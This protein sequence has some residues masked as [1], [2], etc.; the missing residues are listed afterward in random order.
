MKNTPDDNDFAVSTFRNCIPIFSAL[1]DAKR[2]DIILLLAEHEPLNVNQIAE[3]IELSRP[4][5]SHHLKILR[6]VGLVSVDRKGTE[7]NYS[8]E[9]GDA[10][11]TIKQLVET[12]EKA[13]L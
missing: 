13:C 11:V 6:D 8:L 4:A 10:L 1:G 5:I 12:V 3:H 2:Q 7:N 9:L